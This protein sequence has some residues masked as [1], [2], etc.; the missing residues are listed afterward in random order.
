MADGMYILCYLHR[1][2]LQVVESQGS[3]SFPT[4]T[5]TWYAMMSIVE[6]M[7]RENERLKV[8]AMVLHSN[9]EKEVKEIV[10]KWYM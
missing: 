8:E 5:K 7:K 10:E 1:Q 9:W 2:T 3:L 6:R 4:W